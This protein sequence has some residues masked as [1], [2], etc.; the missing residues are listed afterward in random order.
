MGGLGSLTLA[1]LGLALS[2]VPFLLAVGLLDMRGATPRAVAFVGS[3]APALAAI[4]AT[5]VLLDTRR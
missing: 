2:P 4:T 5:T 1:A 3:E